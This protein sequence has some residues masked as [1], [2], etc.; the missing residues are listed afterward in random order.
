MR[1]SA[2]VHLHVFQIAEH[3]HC[4]WAHF[5]ILPVVVA[6]LLIDISGSIAAVNRFPIF[7]RTYLALVNHC[8]SQ[9]LLLNSSV[10]FQ[11]SFKITESFPVQEKNIGLVLFRIDIPVASLSWLK[12]GAS[13]RHRWPHAPVGALASLSDSWWVL[14]GA[15]NQNSIAWFSLWP[16]KKLLTGSRR[17]DLRLAE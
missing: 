1:R 13:D 8:P 14:T 3:A 7:G 10:S 16:P 9:Q 2:H 12:S 11:Y 15:P 5:K 4:P 6:L 17:V